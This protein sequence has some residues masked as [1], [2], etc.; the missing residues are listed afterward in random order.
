MN[1]VAIFDPKFIQELL[2]FT[3]HEFHADG[4]PEFQF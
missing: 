2:L 4:T 3:D 1:D